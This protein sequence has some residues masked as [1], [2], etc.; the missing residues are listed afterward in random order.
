MRIMQHCSALLGRGSLM[1]IQAHPG[2][3]V[4]CLR[5]MVWL[6]QE[7]D[8]TD[9]IIAA[10]ESFVCDRAGVVLVNAVA[11]DAVVEYPHPQCCSISRPAV[12]SGEM[13]GL[14]ADLGRV[15]TRIDPQQLAA[16]PIGVRREAVEGEVKRMRRQVAWLVFQHARRAVTELWHRG[17][18][19]LRKAIGQGSRRAARKAYRITQN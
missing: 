14:A 10:G 17:I 1:R 2:A 6:T 11:H 15:R 13:P 8:A 4:A 18:A 19:P 7:D 5:G 12:R 16:M 3:R 9:R